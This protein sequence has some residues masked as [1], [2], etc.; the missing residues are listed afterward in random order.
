MAK[1]ITELIRDANREIT[2]ADRHAILGLID[3]QAAFIAEFESALTVPDDVLPTAGQEWAKVSPD[4]A[5]HLIERHAE[6]WAHAGQLME[7][8]R[9]AV[10]AAAN[11][12]C[13]H[14]WLPMSKP[15]K[16]CLKCGDV[17]HDVAEVG[18]PS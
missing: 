10:N 4:V 12:I 13:E 9:L 8:W 2:P 6:N 16:G 15:H 14:E 3:Q 1:A 11:P 7:A 18:A 17:R 5:F